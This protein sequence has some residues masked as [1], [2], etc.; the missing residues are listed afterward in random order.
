MDP[1]PPPSL[2]AALA[3]TLLVL[4]AVCALAWWVLRQA[5]RRGVGRSPAGVITVVDRVALDPRRTLFVVRVGAKALLLGGS[6]GAAAPGARP[7]HPPRRRP[8]PKDAAP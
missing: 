8:P 6:D 1:P 3:Q 7:G 2:G 5:A 4:G